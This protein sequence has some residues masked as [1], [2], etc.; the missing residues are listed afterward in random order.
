VHAEDSQLIPPVRTRLLAEARRDAGQVTG[1]VLGRQPLVEVVGADRL[2]RSGD[3]VLVI[4][5]A[6][7]LIELLVELRKLRHL[8]HNRLLHEEGS[9]HGG[10]PLRLEELEPV[11]NQ[12]L[13]QHHARSGEEVPTATCHGRSLSRVCQACHLN[14]VGVREHPRLVRELAVRAHDGVLVLVLGDQDRV[15]NDVAD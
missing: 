1:H 10:E 13:V 2:L 4:T 12:R 6:R 8:A 5:L 9:L 7:H 14:E 11:L 3:Q 15:V